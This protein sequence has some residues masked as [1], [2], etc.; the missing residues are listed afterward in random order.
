MK[1]CLTISLLLAALVFS[2]CSNDA[3]EEPVQSLEFDTVV[4][5]E[6]PAIK[7]QRFVI[8][9]DAAGWKALWAEHAGIDPGLP[10]PPIDSSKEMVLGFTTSPLYRNVIMTR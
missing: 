4:N 10:L 2:G 7:K 1:I 5:S 8:I 3:N 6:R 9:K